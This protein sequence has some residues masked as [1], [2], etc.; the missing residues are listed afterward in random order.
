MKSDQFS[1]ALAHPA[2]FPAQNGR[3]IVSLS[4]LRLHLSIVKSPVLAGLLLLALLAQ[5]KGLVLG[6]SEAG[7][8]QSK[9]GNAKCHLYPSST[10]RISLLCYSSLTP[11]QQSV[12]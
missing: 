11:G 4:Q 7:R 5:I 3:P 2:A 9:A 12:K 6:Q 10:D 1:T 8:Q